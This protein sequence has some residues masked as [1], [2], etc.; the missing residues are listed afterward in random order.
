ME[1]LLLDAQN[2]DAVVQA[3]EG[4]GRSLNSLEGT[5]GLCATWLFCML[6]FKRMS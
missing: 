6:F 2:I 4:I 1:D 3:L 5:V